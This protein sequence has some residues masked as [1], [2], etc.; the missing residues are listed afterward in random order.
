MMNKDYISSISK[1]NLKA[2]VDGLDLKPWVNKYN[3]KDVRYYLNINDLQ[4]ICLKQEY[5]KTGSVSGVHYMNYDGEVMEVAHSR[6]Y[7]RY[8][9]KTFIDCF[10]YVQTTWRPYGSDNENFAEAIAVALNKRF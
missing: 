3:K 9:D 7:N 6:F 5:Y 2:V 10:G 8:F 4:H 1:V